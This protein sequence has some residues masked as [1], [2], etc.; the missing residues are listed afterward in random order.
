MAHLCFWPAST[1]SFACNTWL[2]PGFWRGL[3]MTP[4]V[5]TSLDEHLS[6]NLLLDSKL[7]L[8][9]EAN[10]QKV[11]TLRI[12]TVPSHKGRGRIRTDLIIVIKQD[13]CIHNTHNYL[14]WRRTL[15]HKRHVWTRCLTSDLKRYMVR[16]WFQ[17]YMMKM[18]LRQCS[19]YHIS[20]HPIV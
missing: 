10:C 12:C 18:I 2:K 16:H 4:G 13:S 6:G 17:N 3:W 9:P 8:C 1:F 15:M 11:G 20:Y 5:F 14:Y 7:L 19:Y